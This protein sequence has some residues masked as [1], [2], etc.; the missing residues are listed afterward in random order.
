MDI[1]L[2]PDT[3]LHVETDG[4]DDGSP[5]LL[6]GITVL[7]WDD[8]LVAALAAGGHRVVRYDLRDAGLSTTRD[9]G[10]PEY[11]LRD[12]IGDAA[13]VL[14]ALEIPSAHVAGIGPGGWIAQL[15]ALDHPERVRSLT[16][17]GTRPTAPGRADAD[18]P[19]HDAA[20][21]AELF[22]GPKPDWTD[23]EQVVDAMARSARVLSGGGEHDEE[24][25][26]ERAGRVCDRVAPASPA[27]QMAN[28]RGTLFASLKCGPRWRERLGR[29]K[30]P[31]LVLHGETDPF[32]PLG[33]GE[34]LAREIPGATL[35]T[36]PRTGAVLTP[37]AWAAV[38][39]AVSDHTGRER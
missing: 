28:Q 33:N 35:V 30:A 6:I 10:K 2:T 32:F 12:L 24:A 34:A 26:R 1:A 37:A 20:V 5:L 27:V 36:L 3:S 11:T 19:D 16:L 29:I 9:P 4:P 18:L 14:D 13:A 25:G 17:I 8:A 21:M 22:G 15:L 38:T 23:R 31:T 39:A 7:D